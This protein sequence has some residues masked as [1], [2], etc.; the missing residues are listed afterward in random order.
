MLPGAT[1]VVSDSRAGRLGDSQSPPAETL[2]RSR[3]LDV[4]STTLVLGAAGQVALP[5]LRAC[6]RRPVEPFLGTTTVRPSAKTAGGAS[7][8]AAAVAA[9]LAAATAVK[10]AGRT[11][12]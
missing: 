3:G 8:V 4:P 11:G 6:R 1:A 10:V 7:P 5:V 12:M 9:G 2:A